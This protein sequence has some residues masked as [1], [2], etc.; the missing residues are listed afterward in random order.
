MR[1]VASVLAVSIWPLVLGLLVLIPGGIV[2]WPLFLLV[3]LNH[4]LRRRV[5]RLGVA[6]RG[7]PRDRR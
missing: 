6:G 2:F 5:L 7:R 1:R 3:A 4:R